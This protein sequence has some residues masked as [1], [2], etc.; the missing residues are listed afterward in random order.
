MNKIKKIISILLYALLFW[1]LIGYIILPMFNTFSQAFFTEEGFSPTLNYLSNENNLV[2]IKN[3]LILGL[4]SVLVCGI[5]GILLALYMTFI[6]DKYKKIIHV[7]LL[8]PMMIPGV[9]LV[10]AC[11]QLYGESG[12]ITKA[13]QIFLPF[14]KLNFSGLYAILFVI[15][16]TQYVYFYLNVY[17]ALKYI[18]YS[19]IEAAKGMGASKI[20][21]FKDVIWP[22]IS[23][24]VITSTIVT[25]A[26][27]ISAY[28]APNLIGGG[29]KV[30]STQI[31]R[32][33][34]NNNM[35]I[36][37]IQVIILLVMGISFMLLMQYYGKKYGV[38]S[39]LKSQTFKQNTQKTL[40][41]YVCK[42][43]IAIQII[44]IILPIIAIIY[45][46]FM[47]THSIMM[48]IFPNEFTFENYIAVFENSRVL[49]PMLNSIKMSFITVIAGLLITVPVAYVVVKQNNFK[50][51]LAKFIIM[52]PWSMPASAIAINLIN[53]FNQKNIFALNHSLIGG[54]Y[55]LP[56]AYTIYSLPLLFSSN[57][58]AM[59]SIN[60]GLEESSR[61]LGAS[62]FKTFINVIIPNMMP[63]I[64]SGSILVFIR[65]IG[66]YTIS[67]L[68]Y[69][70]YNR[71]ISISI[72]TN[73]QEFK[74]GISMAYGV[75]LILVCYVA[76]L[77]VFKFD[78][79][80][81][82]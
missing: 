44:I 55:I 62:K 22:V 61:S 42:I 66:E 38:V 41:T 4:G 57:E 18:D 63:G 48:D 27:G 40:F 47:S 50:N 24:A 35:D 21:V 43:I 64:I 15:A 28:S 73:M 9:I 67:A 3:T 36:A 11:I 74:I 70:V 80:K 82:M 71:P 7:L 81:Y 20:Q 14:V 56:I 54:F 68:L 23:P 19:T 31:V 52:I 12:I 30:L 59:K 6:C 34:A 17:V 10:I 13:I 77:G 78:K 8:S 65:T 76:L 79:K 33:K 32:A 45:L 60:L 26:S 69:G 51:R 16:Y 1:I 2:V 37:S 53:A 39:S 29:F 72:V 58:V 46:S 5:L 25:F 75:M 49:K